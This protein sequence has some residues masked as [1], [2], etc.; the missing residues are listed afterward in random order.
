MTFWQTIVQSN[1]FNF[2]VLLLIFAVLANKLNLSDKI[3]SLRTAIANTVNN[4]KAEQTSADKRLKDAKKSVKNLSEELNK[5]HNDALTK[6]Q[7]LTD[8]ILQNTDE[9][10]KMLDKNF[11]RS[12]EAQEKTVSAKLSDETFQSAIELAKQKVIKM[13]EENPE[14][15]NKFIDESIGAL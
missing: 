3:E 8:K 2:A 4:A 10:I 5:R 1:T 12:V 11:R 9:Q 6:A 15:H 13:L 14:L 7:T